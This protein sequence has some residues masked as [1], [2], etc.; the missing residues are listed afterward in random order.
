MIVDERLTTYIDSI[1][2]QIPSYLQEVE[3]QALADEV[4]I[5]RRSMQ[6]LLQFLL[7]VR[8][9]GS[10][11]EIGTAVGFSSMLI[12]E[13]VADAVPIDTIE[14]VPMR[15]Q[16]ARANFETYQKTERI[17]L[18]EGDAGQVLQQLADAG[19]QYDFIFMDA[20]KGQYPVFF[21]PI[22]TLLSD[23][24]I[25]VTDNV[26]QDGDIIE[27]RYAITRRDRTIH[28]RM[29]EF[30]YTLTHSPGLQTVVLPVGDGAAVT[31]RTGD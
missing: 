13:C 5:I 18:L 27:S 28:G 25:L 31:L 8:K 14:K 15:I 6:S 23:D 10:V 16:H 11:L 2:W 19:N 29:R 20:A 4:P 1:S 17:R 7:A 30:L 9:P 21:Q 12:S 24:G 26:L 3:R 22:L